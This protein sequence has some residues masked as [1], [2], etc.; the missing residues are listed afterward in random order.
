MVEVIERNGRRLRGRVDDLLTLSRVDAGAFAAFEQQ[1][2]LADVV[3]SAVTVVEPSVA[4]ARVE[5]D[6]R[7]AADLPAVGGDR[8]QLERVVLNLLTNAVKFSEPGA[9][10]S[11]VLGPEAIENPTTGDR[12]PALRLAVMDTGFGIPAEEQPKLFTRFYRTRE[13]QRRVIQGTGLGLAVVKE[14]VERH[15]GT[16]S[17]RSAA[18]AGTTMTVL[19]P[20]GVTATP[21]RRDAA[22]AALLNGPRF[23]APRSDSQPARR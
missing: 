23:P 8:S 10:V 3:R 7:L 21:G 15:G 6:V 17:V 14:I 4:E 11:V 16:V 2:D 9:T 18:G 19:L 1:V 20:A 5:L 12:S 13:A 22:R